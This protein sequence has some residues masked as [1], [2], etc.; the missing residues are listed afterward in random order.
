MAG[1]RVA[2]PIRTYILADGRSFSVSMN[3]TR[4]L[5]EGGLGSPF[6]LGTDA[7]GSFVAVFSRQ[8]GLPRDCHIVPAGGY[9]GID[10]GPFVE[11]EG[12]LWRKAPNFTS[13]PAVPLSPGAAPSTQYCFNERAEVTSP[14]R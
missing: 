5:F 4:V 1:E 7:R 11:V 13:Q 10:R 3:D 8:D 14:A 9:D 6:V 12:V 2:D